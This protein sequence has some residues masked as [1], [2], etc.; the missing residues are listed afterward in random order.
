MNRLD[1]THSR[2]AVF[3]E[4]GKPLSLCE[5]KLPALQ[6]GETLVE[7]ACC[8]ICGS[9][10]HT[11]RGDRPVGRPTVLGHEMLGRIARLPPSGGPVCDVAG[12]PLTLGDRI[13]WSVAASCGTC[14]FCEAGLPQ[15]CDKLFKYGHESIDR[16]ELSGGLAEFCHLTRGTAIVRVPETLSDY[17]AC[18]ANC[19]TA[20]VAAAIRTAGGCRGKTVVIHGAGML[21]LTAAAMAATDGAANVIVTDISDQRLG[22]AASFGATHAINAAETSSLLDETIRVESNGRG[23]DVVFELSG[24]VIAIEQS[25]T[26]LRTGGQLVLVGSVFPTRAAQLAPELIVRKLLRIDGVHNYTPGDLQSAVAFLA[27]SAADVPFESLVEAEDIL[28][29]V[30]ALL[31]HAMSSGA[32][33]VCV[34]P[35][36]P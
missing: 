20:T 33:R 14:F 2:A 31:Q 23:A 7:I 36:V 11:I 28:A 26:Q 15:K 19:A 30:D 13:T 21:G 17:V 24:A 9:D 3:Y 4:P 25:L 32:V 10:L 5:F 27:R 8:T 34:R 18:P 29:N 35:A 22:R 12:E 6:A 16:R 1:R